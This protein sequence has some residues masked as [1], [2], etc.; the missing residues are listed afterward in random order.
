MDNK[1][2]HRPSVAWGG[3]LRVRAKVCS[4]VRCEDCR[5][6]Q[7][8]SCAINIY[9]T[10]QKVQTDVYINCLSFHGDVHV[11]VIYVQKG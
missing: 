6:E 10:P 1:H 11:I 3:P 7:L 8:A 9:M 5:T 2:T 4:S